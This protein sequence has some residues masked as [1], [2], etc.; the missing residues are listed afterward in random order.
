M[1]KNESSFLSLTDEEDVATQAAYTKAY[2]IS[3]NFYKKFRDKLFIQQL[4]SCQHN[5]WLLNQSE[6]KLNLNA[7]FGLASET[8]LTDSFDEVSI[9][10]LKSFCYS[11]SFYFPVF[12]SL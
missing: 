2:G 10:V 3:S 9:P 1:R 11:I 12:K 8:S 5:S 4:F 7:P 6:L